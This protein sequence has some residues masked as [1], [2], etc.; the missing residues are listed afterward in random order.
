LKTYAAGEL[1]PLTLTDAQLRTTSAL[2]D[3][4]IPADEQSPAASAAA[5]PRFIDEW[6]SAPYPNC[7]L[8]REIIVRGLQWINTEAQR[9][10]QLDFAALSAEQTRLIC[11]DIRSRTQAH[12]QYTDAALFFKHF[13]DLTA[14]GYY[15]TPVG[16]KDLGYVGN[17]PQATFE[18]PSLE[19]LK[20]AGLA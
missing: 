10:F 7:K 5:V 1:W 19:V 2:C 9:R 16:A 13:R 11:E 14:L 6:I 3:L 4:I 8:D 15:T 20:R 18:G 12:P 17:E